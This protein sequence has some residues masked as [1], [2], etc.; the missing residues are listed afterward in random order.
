ML[1]DTL[2]NQVAAFRVYAGAAA[3]LLVADWGLLISDFMLATTIPYLVQFLIWKMLYLE[4][5][6]AS[7]LGFSEVQLLLYYAY[8]ISLSRL[9]NGYDIIQHL[10]SSIHEGTLELQVVRPCPY[11]LQ[12]LFDFWGGG[13]F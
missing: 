10:S 7:T 8:A 9:N 6:T 5:N 12:R 2:K 4:T 13:L 3:K 1:V 11:P